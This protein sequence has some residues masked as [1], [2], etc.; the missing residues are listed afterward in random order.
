MQ[1]DADSTLERIRRSLRTA[2]LP[3]ATPPPPASAPAPDSAMLAGSFAREASALG[4]TVHRPEIQAQA[5]DAAL[6]ILRASGGREILAWAD[7]ELS[8][9]GLGDA[10]RA[11]GFVILDSNVPSDP[12]ARR[13]KMAE[14]GR[15]SVGVTG[16]FGGLAD[17]GTLILLTGLARSRM[18]S[19]LPPIHV[20]LISVG[21]LHPTIAAFFAAHPGAVRAGSNLVFITGPSRTADI[22]MT[23]TVGVHGPKAV[24]IVLVP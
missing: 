20:A 23:L 1:T 7:S 6:S 9:P 8:V 12:A 15:A 10:I 19:L 22:E 5:I 2:H 3:A 17:S 14:L 24:H 16:A 11:A 21:H 13:E 4:V 18:A